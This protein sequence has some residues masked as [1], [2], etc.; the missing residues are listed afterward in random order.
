MTEPDVTP[1]VSTERLED[2]VVE[3]DADPPAPDAV[4]TC[5]Q[6]TVDDMARDLLDCRRRCEALERERD[7]AARSRIATL[8]AQNAKLREALATVYATLGEVGVLTVTEAQRIIYQVVAAALADP[9]G[10]DW[11]HRALKPEGGE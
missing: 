4:A 3:A 2:W 7:H 9:T 8:S 1:R 11:T 5:Q 6:G 10:A